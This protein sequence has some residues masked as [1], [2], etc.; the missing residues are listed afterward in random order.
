MK[1]IILIICL[2]YSSLF[3]YEIKSSDIDVT[4]KGIA[5][6]VYLSLNRAQLLAEKLPEYA[7]YIKKPSSPLKPY[8]VVY[9]VNINKG[10][11]YNLL[12]K[13]KNTLPSAYIASNKRIKLLSN[14]ESKSNITTLESESSTFQEIKDEKKVNYIDNTKESIT[15]KYTKDIF[16]ALEVADSLK[17]F[18]I[19]IR[20]FKLLDDSAFMIYAVNI[21]LNKYQDSIKKIQKKYQDSFKTSKN[22]VL[23]FSNNINEDNSFLY[24]SKKDFPEVLKRRVVVKK[25]NNSES[26]NSKYLKAKKLFTE[27]N[28][29]ETIKIL[30][31]LSD[32]N[33]ANVGINFYL[34]RSYFETKDYE[35]ASAAFERVDMV[36]SNNLRAKLELSQSYM[37]LGLYADA[38]SGFNEVL[39]SNI[40]D[41]VRSNIGKRLDYINGL[42]KKGSF[43]GSVSLG[44]TYDTNINNTT[45]T[46]IFNTPNYQNLTVDDEKYSD[47]YLSLMLNANYNY[48]INSDYSLNNGINLVKQNYSKDDQR[49]NDNTATGITKENKKELQLLSYNL[50][51]TKSNKNSMISVGANLSDVKVS[52]DDY[53]NIYGVNLSYQKRFLSNMSF[54]STLKVSKKLYEQETNKKLNSRN[55]QVMVG[56]SIPTNDYGTFSLVYYNT[57][58]NRIIKDV[59]APDK[60]IN[61]LILGNRYKVTDNLSTNFLYQYNH[62]AEQSND[63]TFKVKRDDLLTT[64]SVGV[65]YKVNKTLN[66]ASNVKQIENESNII[67]HTYDKRTFDIFFKKRF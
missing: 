37:M 50:Q 35:R 47:S 67:I 29:K 20:S 18:N 25:V 55:Y 58:E 60:V 46:R 39:K 44:Y 19:Y 38:A 59:K 42:G 43:F 3:S 4:K 56:Q 40:P 9:T 54:F 6:G 45:D 41:N 36:T 7:I 23:Y 64:I 51:L 17:E 15:V 11:E 30:E 24:S 61:G 26:A 1:K 62:S 32:N 57:Q 31:G 2:F 21:P 66:V 52:G 34:G 22:R 13:I 16:V 63:A 12:K 5:L 28:Y 14:I 53:M 8:F 49:L 33:S 65:D 10:E 48:K 27:K